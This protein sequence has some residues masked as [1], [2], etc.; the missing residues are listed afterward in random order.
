M[1][2]EQ[3]LNG[4][5]FRVKGPTYKGDWTHRYDGQAVLRESRSSIDERIITYDHHCNV[6][7]VGRVGFK[8]FTYVFNKRVN[9]NL[10]FEDLVEFIQEA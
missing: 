2:R 7:K 3:F 8:G 1:T 4:V 10:R 9:V 6:F 5:S